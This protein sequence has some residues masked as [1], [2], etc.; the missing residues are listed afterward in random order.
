MRVTRY[1]TRG[2]AMA[3][4][5]IVLLLLL[6]LLLF[7]AIGVVGG[8]FKPQTEVLTFSLNPLPQHPGL[9]NFAK[10]F[11]NDRF[12]RYLVNSA[13]VSLSTTLLAITLATFGGYSLARFRYPGRR[14]LG[15]LILFAYMFPGSLLVVPMFLMLHRLRLIDTHYALI[16][17][18]TTFALPFCV[19]MLKGFFETLP[20]EVEAAAKVDGCGRLALLTRI[21]IPLSAPGMAAVG[22]F[23]FVLSWSEYIFA[24]TFIH[25][26]SRRT[27][28][29]GLQLIRGELGTDFGFLMAGSV[30]AMMPI[31][32]FFI[33]LQ[34]YMIAGI[35][36]GAV[37]GGG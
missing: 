30:V 23:A 37:K 14:V 31:L 11:A 28:A 16:M 25:T 21:V 36:A 15:Q 33:F 4:L 19:W 1:L 22:A 9:E 8:A 12:V 13:V 20:E 32:A 3:A 18:Y 29:A 10:V 24:L 26:D 6:A 35:T 7:P 34:K 17:S 27:V 2:G 5:Y